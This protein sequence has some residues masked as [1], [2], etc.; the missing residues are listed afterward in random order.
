V[1]EVTIVYRDK[2][3]WISPYIDSG[4]DITLIPKS[5]GEILGFELEEGKIKELS[6]IGEGK[7]AVI[8]KVVKM[9]IGKEKFDCQIAWAL[10]EEVPLLLGRKDIFDHFAI[11]FQQWNKNIL[12]IPKSEF[13][14]SGQR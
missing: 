11:L 7:V 12:F 14:N 5:A 4:A 1:A 8:P 10:I 3:I 13:I 9:T 6:G 2:E